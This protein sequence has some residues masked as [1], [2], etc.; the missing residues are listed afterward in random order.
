MELLLLRAVDDGNAE[1]SVDRYRI[2]PDVR[3]ETWPEAAVSASV[4]F[5]SSLRRCLTPLLSRCRRQCNKT[6][7]GSDSC[8]LMCCGRGYNPYTEK[9]VVLAR[10]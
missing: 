2:W 6:S 8:D 5:G 1:R 4:C 7:S 3:T 9:S 10:E